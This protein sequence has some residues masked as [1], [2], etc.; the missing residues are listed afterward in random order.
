VH[1]PNLGGCAR[2]RS[3]VKVGRSRFQPDGSIINLKTVRAIARDSWGR[4]H[5]EARV[6]VPVAST[7]TPQI[8]SIPLYDPQTR[9]STTLNLQERTFWTNIVNHP[10]STIPPALTNAS[11]TGNGLPQNEFTKEEDLGIH[12][13]EGVVRKLDCGSS[14]LWTP[15]TAKKIAGSGSSQV[16]TDLQA[17]A[18]HERLYLKPIFMPCGA[19][20]AHEVSFEISDREKLANSAKNGVTMLQARAL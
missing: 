17:I 9:I 4:M 11:P 12:D 19:P 18:S 3:E 6:L 20:P 16:T 10:P 7:E 15:L 1:C 5:N 8:T 13:M 14:K 2:H